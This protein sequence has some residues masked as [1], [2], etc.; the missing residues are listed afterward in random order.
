MPELPPGVVPYARSPEFT[1]ETVPVKFLEDHATKPGVW[2]V[3]HVLE[4]RLHFRDAAQG[5]ETLL[6]G[7]QTQIIAPEERH[8][9]RPEGPTRF[10]VEFHR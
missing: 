3:I 2:G 4:G 10:F 7:G 8:A 1:E 5:A 6:T 9:V